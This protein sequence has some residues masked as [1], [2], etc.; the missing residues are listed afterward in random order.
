MWNRLFQI[1]LLGLFFISCKK[2]L[3]EL[4]REDDLVTDSTTMV[5]GVNYVSNS[6]TQLIVSVDMLGLQGLK[7]QPDYNTSSFSTVSDVHNVDYSIS[8]IT[9]AGAGNT[10]YSSVLL[11]NL[12]KREWYPEHFVGFYLRRYLEQIEGVSTKNVALSSFL[13]QDNTPARFHTQNPGDLYGNSW[14]Y[15]MEK[16]YEYTASANVPQNITSISFLKSRLL[17]IV[18][19]IDTEAPSGD[20][21]ITLFSNNDFQTSGSVSDVNEIIAKAKGSQIRINLI[22]TNFSHQLRQIAN[23]TGGFI[24]EYQIDYETSDVQVDPNAQISHVAVAIQNL[25]RLL[26]RQ[27]HIHRC[28][29]QF[30]YNDGAVY[31]SGDVLNYPFNYDGKRFYIDISIP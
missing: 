2:E 1:L 22:G 27:V 5:F 26:S 4:D 31:S 8:G 21:S 12:N 18:D 19:T 25:D 6:T 29:Y 11:F 3:I 15:S 23:E 30:D 7:A 24:S 9:E 17:N 28:T 10:G 20:L 13:M 14:E 16:F